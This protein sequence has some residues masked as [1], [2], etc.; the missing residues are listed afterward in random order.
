VADEQIPSGAPEGAPNGADAPVEKPLTIREIAEAAFDE[1]MVDDGAPNEQP[2]ATGQARP[3]DAQ[4]RFAPKDDAKAG[5]AAGE[6]PTQPQKEGQKTEP[7]PAP[8]QGS[9]SEAP[10]HWSAADRETFARQTPEGQ[11]FLL[12]RHS[13]MES[14]YQ[15]RVQANARA[16]EFTN[17][18]APVFRDPD[19]AKAMRDAGIGPAQA[20]DIWGGMHKRLLSPDINERVKC[21]FEIAARSNID[22]AVF[23]TGRPGPQAPLS[24]EE[25]KDP[26]IKFFADHIGRTSM[27]VQGLRA[28]LQ[29]MQQASQ[30]QANAEALKVTRWGIDNFADEKGP[31]GK[32]LRP[33]FNEV[34]DQIVELF[35]INPNRDIKEAYE[36]ARYMNAQ[37]RQRLIQA[38][39]S[40]VE[41]GHAN[42]RAAQAVRSNVRGLTSPVSKPASDGKPKSLRETI[43]EAADAIGFN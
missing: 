27:E 32:L 3:R 9:S 6:E 10:A 37:T 11:Q 41:Q 26:A 39:R 40:R 8:D 20:L 2:D 30:Q 7:R 17:A 15:R 16:V 19:I 4:G 21:I 25:L 35:R 34:I 23:T 12:R 18:A 29:Q 36:T 5:E 13:E 38:E 43:E 28:Q 33:D 1:T 14:D 31:D 22:P 24:Q 42:G